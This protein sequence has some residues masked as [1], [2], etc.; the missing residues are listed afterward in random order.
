MVSSR[1]LAKTLVELSKEKA[2]LI[3]N[4]EKSFEK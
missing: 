1:S 4:T 3:E 2:E